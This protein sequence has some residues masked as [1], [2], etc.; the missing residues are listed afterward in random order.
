MLFRV[1]IENFYSIRDRQVIDLRARAATDDDANRLAPVWRGASERV[2]KVVSLFGANASGKSNVLKALSFVAWFL[3]RSF[4]V[5]RG[6]PLP[7]ERFNDCDARHAP[8]R[9]ALQIGGLEDINR[10][11]DPNAPFCGYTYEVMFGGRETVSVLREAFYYRPAHAGRQIRLFDR[12]AN[13]AVKA[14]KAFGL[15]GYRQALEKVLRPDASVIATLVQ[16]DHPY[17]MAVA[18]VASRINGNILVERIDDTDANAAKFYF[19]NPA[20]VDAFNA[21]VQRIDLGIRAMELRSGPSGPAA[22][23]H[24]HGLTLPMPLTYQSHGTRQ[25]LKLYP[26]LLAALGRGGIAV[27]DELDAAIH[28]MILPEIVRWFYDPQRNPHHAQL[29]M[30]CHNASLLEDL[31][32]EEVL[33]CD[34][35]ERGR[36]E[37]YGLAD[38]AGLGR[39]DNF[40][41][42]YLGGLFGAVPQIG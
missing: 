10:I 19:D 16:F 2:P 31:S 9:I 21:E 24:H 36:T 37:I 26:L 25:F 34:K 8:T 20:F 35:D 33:F 23:F 17:A 11:D 32:K 29:W 41:K 5:Q 40:Y 14:D 6:Q 27:M 22:V 4:S 3:H 18:D 7:F 15:G 38:V 30:T 39:R 13:G 12:Q 42:K 1:E 28:P